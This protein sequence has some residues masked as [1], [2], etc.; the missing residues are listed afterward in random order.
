MEFFI[1]WLS[2][3]KAEHVCC[4]DS[5]SIYVDCSGWGLIVNNLWIRRSL[6]SIEISIVGERVVWVTLAF[7]A[8]AV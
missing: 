4:G 5:L 2:V 3:N 8:D 6:T 1:S 7:V